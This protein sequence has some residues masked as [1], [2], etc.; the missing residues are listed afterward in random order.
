ML[1]NFS[2]WKIWRRA[3]GIKVDEH[4]KFDE[5]R[6]NRVDLRV[7]LGERLVYKQR[8]DIISGQVSRPRLAK[9]SSSH[10]ESVVFQHRRAFSASLARSSVSSNSCC[11]FLNLARL[12]AAI[13]SA[14]SICFL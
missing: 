2:R 7:K 14:S 5:E 9:L 11:A 1:F 13:S 12:R 6:Q 4:N 8:C 3:C 10:Q